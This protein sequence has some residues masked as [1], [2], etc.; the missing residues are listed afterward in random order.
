MN[1]EIVYSLLL[2]LLTF[3]G[4]HEARLLYPV[5][6]LESIFELDMSRVRG[7]HSMEGEVHLDSIMQ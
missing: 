2:N 7:H 3:Y 1:V 6:A 4:M 5:L